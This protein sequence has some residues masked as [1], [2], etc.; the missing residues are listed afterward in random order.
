V[1]QRRSYQPPCDWQPL[2]GWGEI[3]AWGGGRRERERERE[4]ED[5]LIRRDR[6]HLI[7]EE[8]AFRE[9]TAASHNVGDRF[10]LLLRDQIL[11][12]NRT[13]VRKEEERGQA[14]QRGKP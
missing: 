4:R 13:L 8:I 5:G 9:L 1:S 11:F 7:E 10:K 12:A 3:C 6:W 2:W 14:G